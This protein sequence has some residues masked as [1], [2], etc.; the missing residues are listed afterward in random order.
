[1]QR[2]DGRA[3]PVDFTGAFVIPGL[4]DMPVDSVAK[5][6]VDRGDGLGQKAN[7]N[8]LAWRSATSRFFLTADR[9]LWCSHHAA[10]VSRICVHRC[11]DLS[12]SLRPPARR[13]V[14]LVEG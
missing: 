10:I 6:A 14:T 11:L 8:C 5:V 3:D 9:N 1:M 13:A 7:A 4:W 2:G 12:K